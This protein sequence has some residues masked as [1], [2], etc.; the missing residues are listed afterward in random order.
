IQAGKLHAYC[1]LCL[2]TYA[3]GAGAFIA[4]SPARRADTAPLGSPEGRGVVA[5]AL[6]ASLATL[7]AAAT[8]QI[9]LDKRPSSPAAILGAGAPATTPSATATPAS[10]DVSAA[11]GD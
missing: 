8:Y 2:L 1:V 4:L 7:A 5:G 11:S 10:T 3:M 6:A 9:A